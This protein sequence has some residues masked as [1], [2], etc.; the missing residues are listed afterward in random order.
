[1]GLLKSQFIEEQERGWSA[2]SDKNV[3]AD[4]IDEPFL[5]QFVIDNAS[6][7]TCDY[8]SA[9]SEELI[10]LPTEHL[11]EL[12]YT[13]V[14]DY[15]A[16][17]TD[18]GVPY[19]KGFI[20][21]P[22]DITEVL[23]NLGL[24][25]N[26]DL[27][28]DIVNSDHGNGYVGASYGHWATSSES[29]S[30]SYSW[31]N[32]ENIVKHRT[33]FNFSRFEGDEYVDPGET[34]PRH[35]LDVIGNHLQKAVTVV[36]QET[37]VYRVRS[38]SAKHTWKPNAKELGAPPP[39]ITTGGR[40]NPPGIPYLYTALDFNTAVYEAR[41]NHRTTGTVF[42]GQFALSRDLNVVDLT[43]QLPLPSIFDLDNRPERES[44]LFFDGFVNK[45]S[46]PIT[47]DD[48]IHLSYIPTQVVC[49][50]LAQ[51]FKTLEG[52]SLD[53]IIFPSSLY[54]GGKNLVIFPTHTGWHPEFAGVT[55]YKVFKYQRPRKL[56]KSSRYAVGKIL[57][58][59][60]AEIE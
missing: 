46:Q 16:E 15:F 52:K 37:L 24:E 3:C 20:I 1:M 29:E 60:E 12:I 14:Y 48:K 59:K 23:Y 8:C 53:G 51:C 30:L 34:P 39:E 31:S 45:I 17:P 55:L 28:D 9:T 33:R 42:V 4:C 5:K 25:C 27:W 26:M 43:V 13:T 35:M 11:Q 10:S 36:K 58:I 32:F 2:I 18:A 6:A 7:T 44:V 50:F 56:A 41:A 22:I 38:R 49:E 40:M 47:P 54:N 19:D 57:P 21:D